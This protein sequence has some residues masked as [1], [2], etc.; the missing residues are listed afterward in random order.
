MLILG[1]ACAC[2]CPC[3]R[4]RARAHTHTHTHTHTTFIKQTPQKHLQVLIMKNPMLLTTKPSTWVSSMSNIYLC[5]S[6][7]YYILDGKQI[8][9]PPWYCDDL[10]LACPPPPTHTHTHTRFMKQT[11]QKYLLVL[12]CFSL[13]KLAF[14]FL[15][16]QSLYL[17]CSLK[18]Y[19]LDGKQIYITPGCCD[20]LR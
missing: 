3:A 5:C 2:V 8:Y 15:G 13:Q 20:N 11:L 4:A 16:C 10:L 19:I 17:Y 7:K 6:L 1:F 9:I 12:T 14:Q 18:Y